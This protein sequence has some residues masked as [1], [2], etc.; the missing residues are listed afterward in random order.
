M[1]HTPGCSSLAYS[2][3]H[4]SATLRGSFP[5]YNTQYPPIQQPQTRSIEQAQQQF[6]TQL[7]A[8]NRT[9]S[10]PEGRDISISG[11]FSAHVYSHDP[12]PSIEHYLTSTTSTPGRECCRTAL[13][14][15][16]AQTQSL[17]LSPAQ[18]SVPTW[19]HVSWL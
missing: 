5:P 17:M 10:L 1:I 4:L 8:L 7:S 18:L 12:K 3:C 11:F 6:P 19:R 9:F 14:N 15:N 2:G 13:T 16:S